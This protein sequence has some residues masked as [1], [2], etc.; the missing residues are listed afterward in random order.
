MAANTSLYT[1]AKEIENKIHNITGFFTTTE[2]NRFK[3]TIFNAKMKHASKSFASKTTTDIALDRAGE[4]REK[5]LKIQTFLVDI[6]RYSGCRQ[7][8]SLHTVNRKKY[9]LVFGER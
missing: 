7:C 5:I 3:K 6:L 8:L 1:K 4:N 2:G 9:V